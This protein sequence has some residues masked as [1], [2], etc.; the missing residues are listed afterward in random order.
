MV[1]ITIV[2]DNSTE[3][4]RLRTEH[5]LAMWIEAGGLNILFDTG[6]GAALMAN[7]LALGLPIA[8]TDLMVLSHG[9]YDHTGA[10]AD[11]LAVAPAARLV[12]HPG[13]VIPRYVIRSQQ[14]PHA[15]GMPKPS[16]VA[17][18]RLPLAQITWAVKP[19]SITSAIGITGPI[20]RAT[21]FEDTGGPFFL[22]GQ[23]QRADEI[24]DD[25]ALWLKTNKGLV[26]CVGCSHAGIVN[27]LEHIIHL[28]PKLPIHAVIGG[29]HLIG[30]SDRRLGNT[31]AHLDRL[32]PEILAPCHCT[33]PDATQALKRHFGPRLAAAH[34]GAVFEF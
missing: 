7:A 31:I 34:A 2:V 17:I 12:L 21:D 1:R 3:D 19:L 28:N 30:A 33:G 4:T 26:I 20:P 14:P 22:D 13:T 29:L 18:D 9:H 27:T 10:V 23:G 8:Q 25:Q 6:Q 5:G 15:I 32:S 16:Q 11:V 24:T